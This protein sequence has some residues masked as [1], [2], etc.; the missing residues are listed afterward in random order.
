M[1]R[2]SFRRR[3]LTIVAVLFTS[4]ATTFAQ[5]PPPKP[6]WIAGHALKVRK[7]KETDW[8]KSTKLGLEVYKDGVSKAVLVI[9][10][11]GH[12]AATSDDALVNKK[13]DWNT[14]LIFSV[15]TADEEKFTKDTALYG[16][17]VF[18]NA[19]NGQVLYITEKN[20]VALYAGA[21]EPNKDPVFHYG[22]KMRVRKPGVETF[23]GAKAF[24]LEAYKD[25][26]TGALVYITQD[27]FIAVAKAVP[28]KVPEAKD[29]KRPKPLYGLETRVRKFDEVDFSDKTQKFTI[30]VFKDENTGTLLYISDAGSIAAVPPPACEIKAEGKPKWS[31][32]MI[33]K[34]RPGGEQDFEKGNKYGIEVFTDTRTGYT[35]FVNQNGSIAVLPVAA[36]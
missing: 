23:D 8:E 2:S 16:A 15:R 1:Q 7:G 33:L 9:T 20:A 14:G 4:A 28:A 6:D 11:A 31:H 19:F 5:S 26:G 21:T 18:K 35:L 24:G 30:E 22:L 29:V 32:A 10:S 36:K 13:A 3:W 27:G 17:E 25:T 34:P 12:M